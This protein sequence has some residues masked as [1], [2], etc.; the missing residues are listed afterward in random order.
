M[1]GAYGAIVTPVSTGHRESFSTERKTSRNSGS[2]FVGFVAAALVVTVLFAGD[3]TP[4]PKSRIS[5]LAAVP[6][7]MERQMSLAAVVAPPQATTHK[8]QEEE[9]APAAEAEAKPEPEGKMA[10][11]DTGVTEADLMPTKVKGGKAQE[12]TKSVEEAFTEKPDK[13]NSHY[14][15]GYSDKEVHLLMIF[16]LLLGTA[17]IYYV[18]R[19]KKEE[20]A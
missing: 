4:Q 15:G 9:A 5:Q 13:K 16:C 20:S 10:K 3:G 2:Y 7:S 11:D 8:L 14:V 6:A 17:L 18:W 12:M 1:S 19:A